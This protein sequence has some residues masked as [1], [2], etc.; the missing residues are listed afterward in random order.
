MFDP[1]TLLLLAALAAPPDSAARVPTATDSALAS[2]V[3]P[4]I[5]PG[6]HVRVRTGF[7]VTEGFAGPVDLAGLRLKHESVDLWSQPRVEPIAWSEIDRID[8]R[9]HP[10]TTGVKA[11]AVVGCLL[12]LASVVSVAAYAEPYGDSGFGGA[13]IVLGGAVG[14][15][16]GGAV[17]AL[18]DVGQPAWKTIYERR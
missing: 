13:T 12:G 18:F 10:S 11:G 8:L 9:T 4:L 15:L 6:N 7:G 16:I 1:N 14:A 3:A 2:V 17:G 5:Q